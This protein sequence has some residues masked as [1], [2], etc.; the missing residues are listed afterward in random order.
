MNEV[1]EQHKREQWAALYTLCGGN[2]DK[3]AAAWRANN[4]NAD[5]PCEHGRQEAL[6]EK[7]LMW[8]IVKAI[9]QMGWLCFHLDAGSLAQTQR[10]K[11][12]RPPPGWPDLAC[13][14]HCGEHV[15]LEVKTA[16]G[17]VSEAQHEMHELLHRR[18]FKVAVVRSV[19]EA[20][21]ALEVVRK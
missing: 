6:P 12:G 5:P 21:E 13:Y 15:L 17:V 20:L 3:A 16:S 4:D 2:Y 10:A 11:A 14:G 8:E 7:D 18:G 9:R 19:T 1:A